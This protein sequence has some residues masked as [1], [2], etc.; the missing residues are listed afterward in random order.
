MKIITL[1]YHATFKAF[2]YFRVHAA[3]GVPCNDT[4]SGRKAVGNHPVVQVT[5]NGFSSEPRTRPRPKSNAAM[6]WAL[7]FDRF[8]GCAQ[9]RG[10]KPSL[11]TSQATLALQRLTS[12]STST[13][14][15]VAKQLTVEG[16]ISKIL[17]KDTV[18]RHARQAA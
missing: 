9:A 1:K 5:Q 10:R 16:V 7:Q 4:A 8:R 13:A 6:D 3:G 18:I 14:A 17:H 11:T 15:S 2:R 12:C